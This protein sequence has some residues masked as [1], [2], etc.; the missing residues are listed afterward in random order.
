MNSKKI[1]VIKA[2][3]KENS[4]CNDLG[5]KY[6][7]GAKK[8]GHEIKVLNLT[9]LNLEKFIKCTHEDKPKLPKDLLKSQELITW[10]NHLVFVYPTWWASPPSLLKVFFETVFHS[11]FAF[12]YKESKGFIPKWDKLLPNKS[13]RIMVTMDSPPFYYK[14]FVGDPGYK[15]LKD[16]LNF[17]GIKPV[18][19]K[20]FGSVKMSSENQ[21]KKWL[22]EAYKIGFKEK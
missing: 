18:H 10:A 11:G 9:E 1:L 6:V 19:K 4:Y 21:R 15:T 22:E 7:T 12:K 3:P 8:A 17:C 14:Y 16:I 5:E 20:Y 2:H 13:A